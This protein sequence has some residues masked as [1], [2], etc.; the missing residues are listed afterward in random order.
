MDDSS[1]A[2]D[3]SA[4][5]EPSKAPKRKRLGGNNG[6]NKKIKQEHPTDAI[7]PLPT[8]P[9]DPISISDDDDDDSSIFKEPSP[10]V[11]HLGSIPNQTQPM[12]PAPTPVVSAIPVA[13][14]VHQ[15][16][17][18]ALPESTVASKVP[19]FTPPKSTVQGVGEPEVF[20]ATL[21]KSTA[22]ASSFVI[23]NPL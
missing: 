21:A 6:A 17:S 13:G 12:P 16:A 19:Q 4:P 11:P 20:T 5:S 10:P 23:P 18:A 2:S 7:S 22:S 15:S 8:V 9:H 14:T 3:I 1:S